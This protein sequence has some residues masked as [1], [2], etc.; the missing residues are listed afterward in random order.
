M[1]SFSFTEVHVVSTNRGINKRRSR[2]STLA[3]PRSCT[4]IHT[5]CTLY[6]MLFTSS[7]FKHKKMCWCTYIRV[8]DRRPLKFKKLCGKYQIPTA[9]LNS[10]NM[11]T[12]Q[13]V[14]YLLFINTHN[15][16]ILEEVQQQ[17]LHP[18]H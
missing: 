3:I 4:Y 9:D 6:V 18:K 15:I 13:S 8:P 1:K 14:S 10:F 11:K 12:L 5:V 7:F 16:I 17:R 2:V